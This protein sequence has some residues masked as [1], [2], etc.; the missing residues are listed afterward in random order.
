MLIV[1]TA[2]II[3]TKQQSYCEAKFLISSA[4]FFPHMQNTHKDA[5]VFYI[6]TEHLPGKRFPFADVLFY[7]KSFHTCKFIYKILCSEI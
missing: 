3:I 1:T 4:I 7:V 6:Y 2:T 5:V